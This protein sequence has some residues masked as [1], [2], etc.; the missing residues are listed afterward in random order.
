MATGSEVQLVMDAAAQLNDQGVV[1]R[2]VSMPCTTVFDRQS[3]Q[4]KDSVLGNVPIVAVEAG[5][6]DSWF[7][8]MVQ[9]GVKGDVVGMTTFGESAPAGALFKFFNITAEN[10]VAKAKALAEK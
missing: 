3:D 5:T 8:Y 9:A 2:V 4:S 7:K 6:M 1:A 10:V